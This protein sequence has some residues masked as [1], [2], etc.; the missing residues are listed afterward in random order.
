MSSLLSAL[1]TRQAESGYSA[2]IGDA[3]AR[4]CR[5]A[6]ITARAMAVIEIS[7]IEPPS[8]QLSHFVSVSCRQHSDFDQKQRF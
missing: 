5:L 2:Q 6:E 1:G 3:A 4:R 8:P 7:P